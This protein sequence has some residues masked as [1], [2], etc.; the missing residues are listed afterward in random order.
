MF[1]AKHSNTNTCFWLLG[2]IIEDEHSVNNSK[3]EEK[4][5]VI[6]NFTKIYCKCLNILL[7]F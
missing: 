4:S 3:C 1:F 6:L 2:P 5:M 7:L